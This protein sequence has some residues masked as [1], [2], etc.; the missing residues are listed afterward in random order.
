[1]MAGSTC[2]VVPAVVNTA[3]WNTSGLSADPELSYDQFLYTGAFDL[4]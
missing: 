1:M 3:A 2:Q 4:V